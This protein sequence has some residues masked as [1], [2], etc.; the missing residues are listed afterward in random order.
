MAIFEQS[1]NSTIFLSRYDANELL[2]SYSNHGF[3]LEEMYWPTLEHYYQAMKFAQPEY[4]QQIRICDTPALATKMG[5]A[6]KPPRQPDWKKNRMLMMIRGFYIKCRA[7]EE[8]ANRL[9]ETGN[10]MLIENSM[11]DY[12]WGCG[13]DRLGHNTYG[14]VLM[15][16]RN[17]LKEEKQ[18]CSDS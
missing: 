3:E 5:H 10:D 18:I 7:F 11:Y 4:R 1:E 2:S 12:F 8:V 6:R 14:K 13:R 17:K 9:L 16:V 15:N